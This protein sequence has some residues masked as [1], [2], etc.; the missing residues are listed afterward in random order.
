M[1][2]TT[3]GTANAQRSWEL[4]ARAG[5]AVSGVLHILI[6]VL[7]LRVAFGSGGEQAD[8]SG[9]L[10]TIAGTPFGGVVLWFSVVAFVAL[11]RGRRRGVQS[12]AAVETSDR[13]KSAGRAVVYLALAL[14][15]LQLRAAV[16]GRPA[17]RRRRT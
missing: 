6:G 4:A 16:A 13:A 7:A 15:R 1:V 8:Q 3:S 10:S 14:D 9:A 12:G 5:Y 17:R 2:A 11:G